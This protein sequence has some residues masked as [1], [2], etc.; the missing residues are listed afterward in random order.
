MLLVPIF[1]RLSRKTVSWRL[2]CSLGTRESLHCCW[3][4]CELRTI[5]L[6]VFMLFM[7]LFS[8][9]RVLEELQHVEQK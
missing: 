3:G 2:A 4:L 7:V 5:F 6:T 8:S 1:G 9:S